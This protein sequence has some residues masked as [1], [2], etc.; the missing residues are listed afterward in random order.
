VTDEAKTAVASLFDAT[1][2]DSEA[3]SAFKGAM[4]SALFDGSF[5]RLTVLLNKALLGE[6]EVAAAVTGA[7]PGAGV[8]ALMAAAGADQAVVIRRVLSLVPK[9]DTPSFIVQTRDKSGN[10]AFEHAASLGRHAALDELL[11][12]LLAA[13]AP[14]QWGAQATAA[15]ALGLRDETLSSFSDPIRAQIRLFLSN[16]AAYPKQ[17][18]PAPAAPASAPASV[19]NAANAQAMIMMMQHQMMMMA[20]YQQQRMMAAQY[21]QQMHRLQ[22]MQ[23]GFNPFAGVPPQLAMAM[24]AAWQMQMMAQQQNLAPVPQTAADGSGKSS[25]LGPAPAGVAPLPTPAAATSTAPATE[26]PPAGGFKAMIDS[27]KAAKHAANI[28]KQAQVPGGKPLTWAQRASAAV[29]AVATPSAAAAVTPAPAVSASNVSLAARDGLLKDRELQK[30][31]S[32]LPA[33][34]PESAAALEPLQADS[35]GKGK[36]K[37]KDAKKDGEDTFDQFAV[38]ATKFGFQSTYKEELYTSKLDASK[39]SA[40]QIAAAEKLAQEILVSPAGTDNAH[41]LEERE[42]AGATKAAKDGEDEEAK[43]SAVQRP[44]KTKTPA[45]GAAKGKD[46]G[47][48][49]GSAS[50]PDS[51]TDA[52]VAAKMEKSAH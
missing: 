33:A 5:A 9:K 45:A 12:A 3:V 40:A 4:K 32:F 27:A 34:T 28:G 50:K 47:K 14:A 2:T 42:E 8:T 11:K 25:L 48:A 29:H 17:F 49:K 23:R 31:D 6:K 21:Q 10:N 16:P 36:R 7:I 20:Q 52:G 37:G 18:K 1:A 35:K 15:E 19:T 13:G 26:A 43:Y 44:G 38:N 22:Q 46:K 30:F 51:F 41:I 39:F 24:M